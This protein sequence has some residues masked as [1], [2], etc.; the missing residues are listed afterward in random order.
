MGSK[1]LKLYYM[2]HQRRNPQNKT[3]DFWGNFGDELSPLVVTYITGCDVRWARVRDAD[4]MAI[5]SI[6]DSLALTKVAHFWTR[7]R[8]RKTPL[9][10]WGTGVMRETF[11]YPANNLNVLALRGPMSAARLHLKETNVYGD[12]GLFASE[13]VPH[14]P[15]MY[16]LGIVPHISERT[17]EVTKQFCAAFPKALIIDVRKHP[18]DVL[19]DIS[20]C[21]MILSS[22]LHGLV[23]ADSYS[24]PNA[25]VR[26]SDKV[27]GSGFKFQ[28]Y[29]AGIGRPHM[30]AHR[31]EDIPKEPHALENFLKAPYQAIDVAGS[32]RALAQ[33][34]KNWM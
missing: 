32:N 30:I 21:D 33:K 10:I 31:P 13:L 12:P 20:S 17:Y 9:A 27:L 22:S 28:D 8:W 26:F 11:D 1:V 18:I 3:R 34:L 24:I 15:R 5:G 2:M 7:Y 16:Q 4:L 6:L 19:K 29:A 14:S 23:V 25:W